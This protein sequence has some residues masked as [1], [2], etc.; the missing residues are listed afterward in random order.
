MPHYETFQRL[1]DADLP[2]LSLYQHVNT[3]ALSD[4]VNLAEIGRFTRPRDRYATFADWFLLY[5]DVTVGCPPEDNT[6]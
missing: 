2:A 4:S 3:Y 6:G 1:Y 5:R